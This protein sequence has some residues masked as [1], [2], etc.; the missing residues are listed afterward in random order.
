MGTG[1]ADPIIYRYLVLLLADWISRRE[2]AVV[3]RAGHSNYAGSLALRFWD[4]SNNF[5]HIRSKHQL[6]TESAVSERVRH[7]MTIIIPSRCG[8]SAPTLKALQAVTK[9]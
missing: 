7:E 8:I 5:A 6:E 1:A 9:E 2:N 4:K 3:Y